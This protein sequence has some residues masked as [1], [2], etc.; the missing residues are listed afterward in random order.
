MQR[1]FFI[2]GVQFRPKTEIDKALKVMKVGDRLTLE[3]EPTNKFD[4][5][6]VKIIYNSFADENTEIDVFLG[7]VP[8][9]FSAEV[10]AMLE[11]YTTVE[12]VVEE[13]DLK[14]KFWEMCKVTVR[15]EEEL[16]EEDDDTDETRTESRDI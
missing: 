6:A 11:V 10:S 7:Y 12:C 13:I 3:L 1:S 5:N 8:K 9:K 4:S 14:A 2:A 15:D 16:E